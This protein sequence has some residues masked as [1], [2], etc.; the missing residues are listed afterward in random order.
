MAVLGLTF[1]AMG[2]WIGWWPVFPLV[3]AGI[4]FR[5]VGKRALTAQRPEILLAASWLLAPSSL[6]LGIAFTGGPLSP[7]VF[8]L[9]IP[10]STLP[11]RFHSRGVFAGVAVSILLLIAVTVGVDAA[12]VLNDPTLFFSPLAVLVATV[13]LTMALSASEVEHRGEAVIDALTGMLNRKALAT[14]VEELT[15]QSQVA[16]RSV[17]LIIADIDHFKRIND[18][19]G[20]AAGDVVL[21]DVAYRI[22][23]EL[24]AYDLAYRL[25]GEEFA[26][27]VPG[28]SLREAGQVA[29]RLRIAV[30]G[31]AI[32]ESDV[33]ISLGVAVSDGGP[34]DY[35]SLFQA[36]DESLYAA[37]RDGR[38]L[39]R[40]A[41][42][43]AVERGHVVDRL[44]HE[45]L[46]RRVVRRP[47]M[48]QVGLVASHVEDR[49]DQPAAQR[50]ELADL[51]EHVRS[52]HAAREL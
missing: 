48:D 44:L 11:A 17:G 16:G 40:I 45:D 47:A 30:A 19:R 34:L 50:V 33:T 4:V 12:A 10:A 32:H 38:N 42:L 23:K 24:R 37:K 28:A 15:A 21:R 43:G 2:P 18:S 6:A 9:A 5:R 22:R 25:G 49:R 31:S 29:E 35:N 13:I 8:W 7:A 27:L 26:V 20:H 39:V 52:L 46:S 41:G 51:G 36:A 3:L 14:R 1:V